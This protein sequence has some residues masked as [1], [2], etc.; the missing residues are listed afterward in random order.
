MMKTN[1]VDARAYAIDE[2]TILFTEDNGRVFEVKDFILAQPEV[3]KF[4]WNSQDFYPPGVEPKSED[5]EPPP[6]KPRAKPKKDKK[7][8]KKK[9]AGRKKRADEPDVI[10][11]D[12]PEL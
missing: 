2:K 3:Y 5:E 8:K 1:A 12:D 6:Q 11:S 7:K 9:K 4:T 10:V